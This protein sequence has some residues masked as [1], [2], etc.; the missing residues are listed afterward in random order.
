MPSLVPAYHCQQR[1][2]LLGEVQG[3]S[4][5][6]ISDSDIMGGFRCIVESYSGVESDLV[7]VVVNRNI[8]R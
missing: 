1:E 4:S 7:V 3:G 5:I 2:A 8:E 6:Q